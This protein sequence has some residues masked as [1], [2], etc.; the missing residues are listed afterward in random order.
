MKFLLRFIFI[1]V[2]AGVLQIYLPWWVVMIVAL[3]AGLM[4]PGTRGGAFFSGFLAIFLLWAGYAFYLD[5]E[6]SAILTKRVAPIL[7]LPA[8]ILLVIITGLIGGLA[9]GFAALTGQLFREIF[10]KKKRLYY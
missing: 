1:L 2:F 6:T 3:L 10:R 4:I 9:A 8:P 7:F 5:M